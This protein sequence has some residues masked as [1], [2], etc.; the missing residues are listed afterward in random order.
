VGWRLAFDHWGHGYAT[1]A[2]HASLHHAF[3]NLGVPE[4]VAFT[5]TGNKRSRRV[6]ERLGMTHDANGDFDHPNVPD[7]HILKRHV[8]YR[9]QR[10][11]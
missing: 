3:D 2:A 9:T 5:A 11:R 10:R 4:V 1:E 6:M 7:G 8:L